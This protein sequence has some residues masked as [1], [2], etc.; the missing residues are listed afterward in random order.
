MTGIGEGM[1]LN[2]A[3][4]ATG[5]ISALLEPKIQK[6]KEWNKEKA[7]KKYLEEPNLMGLIETYLER[8]L[9]KSLEISTIVCPQNKIPLRDIFE[10]IHLTY[11]Q[12]GFNE[13]VSQKEHDKAIIDYKAAGKSYSIIDEAG[14]GKSTFSKFLVTEILSKSDRIPILFDLSSYDKEKTLIENIS[15]DFDEL[16]KKFDRDLFSRLITSGKLFIILDGFDEASTE[17]QKKL[18]VE[19]KSLNEKKKGS[20]I[21]LTSRP[22]DIFPD[23]VSSV[24]LNLARLTKEQA[25]SMLI[26]YDKFLGLDFGKRIIDEIEKVPGRF[27]ETPLLVSLLYRTYS[28]NNSIA[29][30]IS[31]F[32]S[33][34]FDALYKGHDL[35]KSGYVREKKSNLDID[36]FRSLLRAFSFLYIAKSSEKNS[37]MTAILSLIDEAKSLCSLDDVS[38]S[39]YFDDLLVAV[40][41][42]AKD[43]NMYKFMHRTI[44]EYFAA[45]YICMTNN[46]DRLISRIVNGEFYHSFAKTIDF[47]KEVSP[48]FFREEVSFKIAN[49][50]VDFTTKKDGYIPTIRFACKCAISYWKKDHVMKE[51]NGELDINIPPTDLFKMKSMMC[52]YG[53]IGDEQFIIAAVIS[54]PE[55]NIPTGAWLDISGE[56]P[57]ILDN[58]EEPF[59][60]SDVNMNGIEKFMDEGTWYSV[61]DV[62]IRKNQDFHP[63]K[64]SLR[65]ASFN[66]TPLGILL[67]HMTPRIISLQKCRNLIA[68]VERLRAAREGINSLLT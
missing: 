4:P 5:L 59:Q 53:E 24:N 41:L 9:Q 45:E 11:S 42:L 55:F 46:R 2:A 52:S 39:K 17:E 30:K 27:L 67:D 8:I 36:R 14:M 37:S 22:Q 50:Y 34:I 61:D 48:D 68:S 13:S 18:K 51:K 33:E 21:L 28:F 19:I 7:L 35:T 62:A 58:V 63:I 66:I 3:K 38:S 57:N 16:D 56:E 47:V 31:V 60:F 44:A 29:D 20:S 12:N 64:N 32:Y 25:S 65:F 1:A 40:P 15:S 43:G 49:K 6:I 10:P 26:K 54:A 23:L